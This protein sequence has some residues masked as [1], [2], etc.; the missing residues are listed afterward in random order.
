VL[1]SEAGIT[2]RCCERCHCAVA[3]SSE[4]HGKRSQLRKH[5]CAVGVDHRFPAA[6]LPGLLQLC[7]SKHCLQL[8]SAHKIGMQLPCK[9]TIPFWVSLPPSLKGQLLHKHAASR[10]SILSHSPLWLHVCMQS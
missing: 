4:G 2:S 10:A 8:P 9:C 7:Y 3:A 5:K 6:R 1:N